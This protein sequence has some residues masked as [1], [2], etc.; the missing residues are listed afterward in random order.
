MYGMRGQSL[1]F[2]LERDV[3]IAVYASTLT[4]KAES[5]DFCEK[6]QVRLESAAAF[7]G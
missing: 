6:D 4:E 1:G 2:F 5:D 3:K 7:I